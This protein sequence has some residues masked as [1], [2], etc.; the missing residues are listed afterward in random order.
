MNNTR[1]KELAGVPLSE[2]DER[3]MPMSTSD[4]EFENLKSEIKQTME[5][6]RLLQKQYRSQTGRD[7]TPFV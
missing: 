3:D 7:F 5:K 4:Q 1:L 6:L 2:Q